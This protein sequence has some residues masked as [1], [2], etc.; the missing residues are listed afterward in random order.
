MGHRQYPRIS[1]F[2]LAEYVHASAPRRRR[3]IEGQ[4]NPRG[5]VVP[6]YRLIRPVASRFLRS[7]GRDRGI[8]DR[9]ILRL[10]AL[11][12]ASKWGES[13]LRNSVAVLRHLPAVKGLNL[14]EKVTGTRRDGSIS[15][16]GTTVSVN[17]TV[18]VYG[19]VGLGA[20]A[21]H[22]SKSRPLRDDVGATA[23]TILRWF[24][25]QRLGLTLD[26]VP[27][28]LCQVVDVWRERTFQAPPAYKT[29]M[30]LVEAS[31]REIA[32]AWPYRDTSGYAAP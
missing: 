14:G 9:A 2:P 3:I 12:P 16:G 31:C 29:R 10:E 32:T 21:L 22:L 15:L 1:L 17:P 7:G 8:V 25:A 30:R 23:A 20:V 11:T 28:G 18:A 24:V 26:E 5:E 13:D 6:L 27:H 19:S 4:A